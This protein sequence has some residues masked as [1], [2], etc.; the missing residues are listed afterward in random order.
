MVTTMK[1]PIL[2]YLLLLALLGVAAAAEGLF[3]TV[4]RASG[5]T[6][7]AALA[8]AIDEAIRKNLGALL[9]GSEELTGDRLK[10][11]LVQFSRGT[12]TRYEVLE[13]AQGGDGVV[14][15]VKVTVDPQAV[16]AAA[17]TLR[18]GGATGGVERRSKCSFFKE[19]FHQRVVVLCRGFDEL[20]T[21]G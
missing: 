13:T 2:S 12:A 5:R 8:N 3:E 10:E 21:D 17:R 4:V 20:N 18:E 14:L 6:Q 7:E 9:S 15:T 19:F 16:R 1:R 11:R